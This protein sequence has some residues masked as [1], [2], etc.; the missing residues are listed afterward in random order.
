[1]TIT[2]VVTAPVA[3]GSLINTATVTAF[4]P[5]P[6]PA[7]NSATTT[8]TISPASAIPALSDWMLVLLAAALASVALRKM[9]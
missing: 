6:N 3:G 1:M 4:E 8:T 5:D 9:M 2:L 7:N